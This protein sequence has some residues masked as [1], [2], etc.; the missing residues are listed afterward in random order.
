MQNFSDLAQEEHFQIRG[1]TE[2]VGKMC[3]VQRKKLA[4]YRKQNGKRYDQGYY[5]SV[6]E[7]G[8]LA[9]K[10]HEYH[11]PCMTFKITDNQYGRLS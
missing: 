7:S 10:W 1:W 8:I 9:F 11:K 3:F 6:I 5:K 2:G 4:I